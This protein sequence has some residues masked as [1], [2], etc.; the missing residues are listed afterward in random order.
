MGYGD[1]VDGVFGK[2]ARVLHMRRAEHDTSKDLAPYLDKTIDELFPAPPVP[3][4]TRQ[5]PGLLDDP[6]MEALSWRSGHEP[7]S[8]AYRARHEGDYAKNLTA[9]ATWMHPKGTRRRSILLYAH[10]WLQTTPRLEEAVAL[11]MFSKAMDVDVALVQ[12]PFHGRRNA[13]GQLFGGEYFWSADLVRSLEAVRQSVYDVRAAMAYFRALGYEEVGV[14]GISLGGSIAM[15]TA[16]LDPVPDYVIPII[17]HLELVEAIEEAEILWRMKADLER[18]GLDKAARKAL[19]TRLAIYDTKPKLAPERQLWL[20]ARED[21]FLT[22]RGVL[23]Q[24]ERWGNPP[25][26]WLTGG[27]MTFMFDLPKMLRRMAAMPRL[28]GGPL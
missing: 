8:A 16:C 3:T 18:F 27:H 20:A 2:L 13:R 24:W 14:A 19:F 10:I 26:E 7:L 25:I 21:R 6:R 22:E 5:A 15:L 9:H 28:A 12:L 11:P 1:R 4:V 23:Q 17:S